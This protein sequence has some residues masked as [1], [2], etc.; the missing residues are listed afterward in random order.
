MSYKIQRNVRILLDLK[1]EI[2]GESENLARTIEEEY[3]LIFQR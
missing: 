2:E 1:N 3:C